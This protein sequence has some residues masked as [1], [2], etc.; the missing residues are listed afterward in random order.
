MDALVM[1]PSI[2]P[3]GTIGRYLSENI[4]TKPTLIQVFGANATQTATD[5]VI[6][7]ADL[8]AIGLTPSATN[9]AESLLMAI[10]LN[11][12]T[13]LSTTNRT[14]NPDQSLAI[15]EG[16]A[17]IANRGTNQYYQSSFN[18]TAQKINNTPAI[19]PDDY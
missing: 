5:L 4:V 14:S 1:M 11:S 7:K 9:S 17:Q 18:L 3:R 2:E 12:K 6:K 16:Y 13:T 10:A 15:E 8:V 19:D